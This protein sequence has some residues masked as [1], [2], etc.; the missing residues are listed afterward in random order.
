MKTKL[1][2]TC[3]MMVATVTIHQSALSQDISKPEPGIIAEQWVS[4]GTY[5]TSTFEYDLQSMQWLDSEHISVFIRTKPVA[6]MTKRLLQE[7]NNGIH[8]VSFYNGYEYYGYTVREETIDIKHH[9]STVVNSWDYDISGGLLEW[10]RTPQQPR[11]FASASAEF[12][13]VKDV[14]SVITKVVI[15]KA[16]L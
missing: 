16:Q 3:L 11:T 10:I 7:D 6:L 14:Q 2:I 9:Q 12:A 4:L 1:F 8:P 15:A 5:D 13:F